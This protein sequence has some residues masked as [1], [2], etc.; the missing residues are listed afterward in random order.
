MQKVG[1][2]TTYRLHF[3]L[4]TPPTLYPHQF[5]NHPGKM[6]VLQGMYFLG[7]RVRRILIGQRNRRL[8]NNPSLVVVLVDQM[9]GDAGLF[10]AGGFDRLVDKAPIHTLSAVLGQEGR[11]DVDHLVGVGLGEVIRDFQQKASQDHPVDLRCLKCIQQD[12]RVHFL[13]G[14][15]KS[16][17]PKLLS[18]FQHKGIRLVGRDQSD[19]SSVGVLEVL[20][21]FFGIGAAAGGKDGE[22][23]HF[24]RSKNQEIRIKITFK[25]RPECE[26]NGKSYS[27][28]DFKQGNFLD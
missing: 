3:L 26:I 7:N 20:Y 11:V 14:K 13:S 27:A 17:D 21:D 8:K 16:R 9:D 18:P 15:S 6:R 10:V 5:P 25:V 12:P 19:L 22:A 1:R 4:L 24:L 28:K 23:F 2:L